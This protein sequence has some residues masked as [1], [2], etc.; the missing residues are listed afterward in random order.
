M[1]CCSMLLPACK[2]QWLNIKDFCKLAIKPLV[3]WNLPWWEYQTNNTNQDIFSFVLPSE[4][5]FTS[6]TACSN[7]PCKG[8]YT[9]PALLQVEG[10]KS[11]CASLSSAAEI[12]CR[13]RTR[14]RMPEMR[15]WLQ[16][17]ISIHL[18]T[19]RSSLLSETAL[20]NF[21]PGVNATSSEG[22]TYRHTPHSKMHPERQGE[23]SVKN[24]AFD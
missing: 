1:G 10:R 5:W 11:R 21:R 12:S 23:A 20:W 22:R 4:S 17:A 6:T 14:A 8:H 7:G 13:R 9:R 18:P 19:P 24:Y 3:A 16:H 2:S 15:E